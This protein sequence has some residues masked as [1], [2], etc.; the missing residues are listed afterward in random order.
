MS[1]THKDIIKISTRYSFICVIKKP[2]K[3]RIFFIKKMNNAKYEVF[4]KFMP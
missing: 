2:C 1:N 3:S 4:F